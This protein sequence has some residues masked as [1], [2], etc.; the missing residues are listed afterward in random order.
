MLYGCWCCWNM[1]RYRRFAR[2]THVLTGLERCGIRYQMYLLI[3][4]MYVILL[5][6]YLLLLVVVFMIHREYC[7]AIDRFWYRSFCSPNS[8]EL[9]FPIPFLKEAC[10]SQRL[11]ICMSMF[12]FDVVGNKSSTLLCSRA[13]ECIIVR[14]QFDYNFHCG[15][16][17]LARWWVT[18]Q[19]IFYRTQ[20]LTYVSISLNVLNLLSDIALDWYTQTA[21]RRKSATAKLTHLPKWAYHPFSGNL[22][23]QLLFKCGSVCH[24]FIFQ[25]SL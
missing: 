18:F 9:N 1:L 20:S 13:C 12:S 15:Y 19:F 11:C 14:L 21:I 17:T 7:V 16:T 22:F 8:K 23:L 24:C 4:L 25:I 6:F 3:L 5:W 10:E 2:G